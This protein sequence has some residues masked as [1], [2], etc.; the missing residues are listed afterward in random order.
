VAMVYR[1]RAAFNGSTPLS[2]SKIAP[3]YMA[4]E[5]R[6]LRR[7][8]DLG[9]APSLFRKRPS[10]HT[11]CTEIPCLDEFQLHFLDIVR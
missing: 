5:D 4:G 3:R 11:I 2:L 7:G 6:E 9:A 8:G 1:P 10:V